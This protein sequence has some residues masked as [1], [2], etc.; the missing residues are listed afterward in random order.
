[1]VLAHALLL[2]LIV[3][4]ATCSDV[5]GS[6]I[7]STEKADA[8][9]S[10]SVRSFGI[11]I[12]HNFEPVFVNIPEK[13]PTIAKLKTAV[14]L[15]LLVE[16]VLGST[17]TSFCLGKKAKEADEIILA[18]DGD[19]EGEAISWHVKELLNVKVP[20]SRAIFHEVTKVRYGFRNYPAL[21]TLEIGNQ[22]AVV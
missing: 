7:R 20:F 14:S 21:A 15:R 4:V 5:W 3:L 12:E 10:P 2:R 9:S 16:R 19:R 22:G 11:D 17:L 1:M 6:A 8:I 13:A 18:T